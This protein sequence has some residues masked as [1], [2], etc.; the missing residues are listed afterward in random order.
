MA[1]D[2]PVTQLTAFERA[3]L[4]EMRRHHA[5]IEAAQAKP[6]PVIDMS[7]P[8]SQW[9]AMVKDRKGDFPLAPKAPE[10]EIIAGCR[11]HKSEC[12]FDAKVDP[13]NGKVLDLLN[14]KWSDRHYL[15][16]SD[17]GLIPN[18]LLPD[19]PG[20]D[21]LKSQAFLNFLW[22]YRREDINE[23][24]GLPLPDHVRP[25]KAEAK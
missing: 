12:T 10:P 25:R 16:A 1:K 21:P 7:S 20:K 3:Q 17:G 19:E 2:D 8:T 11:S 4:E 14:Y 6:Q 18:G 5:A 9:E 22:P 23:F 24:V 15:L 13:R